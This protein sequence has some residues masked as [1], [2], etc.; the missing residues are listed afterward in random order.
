[1]EFKDSTTITGPSGPLDVRCSVP[2]APARAISIICHP[3]PVHGGTMQN[4][5]VTTLERAMR[6]LD[7]ITVCFNFRGVGGSVGEFAGG[8]GELDDLRAVHAFA[9]AHF[10]DLPLWLA[11]FS[12]GS[13]IST[14]LCAELHAQRLVSIAPPV[15]SWDFSSAVVTCPWLI[16]QGDAD[17]VVAAQ[18]VYD[19]AAARK[20][21][22][23][24]LP[25]T[26]FFHGK[27]LELRSVVQH[28]IQQP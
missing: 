25:A 19:F 5:V 26:H 14:S 21:Q 12:F 9:R 8:V 3:H 15:V 23:E 24:V 6:E 16:V 4:K 13:F 17:E 2:D 28:W 22:L 1:V 27:L 10:P 11:G 7:V 20:A 18:A